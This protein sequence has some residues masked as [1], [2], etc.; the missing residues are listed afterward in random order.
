M[1]SLFN[2][3]TSRVE[4]FEPLGK[5]KPV[6]LYACGPTVYDRAHVGH[7]RVTV[8]VDTLVR[9]LRVLYGDVVYVR[10]ITDVDDKIN[11]RAQQEKVSIGDLT[12]RVILLHEND[13]LY[14]RNLGP[15]HE[16][17]VTEHI[18]CIIETI[19]RIVRNGHGYVKNG[20]VFF[21]VSSYGDYGILS[22]VDGGKL[23]NAVRIED[24]P[25]KRNPLDFVLWKPSSADDDQSIRFSS[26]WGVGRP[27][28]HIEC[29]AMS[30]QYLGSDFDIHC[31]GMD[32]KFPHHENEIA[33]S[34]CA[35]PG[36]N[37]AN[38]WFHVGFL[39]VDGK[40]MSKSLGN[41]VTI[42]ELRM[43]NLSGCVVRLAVARNHYRKPLNFDLN[44]I[45]ESENLLRGLHRNLE[46]TGEGHPV[47]EEIIDDLCD[48]L[49]IPKTI[50]TLGKF[51]KNR[52]FAKLR[53][54]LEFL[55][56]FDKNLCPQIK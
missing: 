44:L 26:P 51:K 9:L 23:L 10:N 12:G 56:L 39:M 42:D 49:N 38:F 30:Q 50:A 27:G 45:R 54:A 8:V 37:F 19:D 41:F 47:P 24:N 22:H 46:D 3:L 32:L 20:H 55:G 35:F 1:L 48:D 2:T 7:G 31:G 11:A 25:D 13:M 6:G 36:S 14:L 17:R 33:Q 34:R 52:E 43:N 18:A 4:K 21:S 28:W 53:G 16:P 5:S 29:S 40:K 15:T